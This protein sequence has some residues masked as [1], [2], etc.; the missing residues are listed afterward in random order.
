MVLELAGLVF[1]G[2]G[3][4]NDLCSTYRDLTSWEEKDLLVDNEWLCLA[5]EKK[6][7]NGP[8][9][10]YHWA[11]VSNVPSKVLAGTHQTVIAFNK[12]K[13]VKY[14]IAQGMPTELILMQKV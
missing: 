10:S 9:E 3:L 13:K 12:D 11:R 1:T 7:I 2:I 6:M 14:R 4:V 8:K 5:I